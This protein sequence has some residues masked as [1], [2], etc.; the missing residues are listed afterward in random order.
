M[1]T[2]QIGF[3][4]QIPYTVI[5]TDKPTKCVAGTRK[6]SIMDLSTYSISALQTACQAETASYYS[7]E[8]HEPRYCV[9]LFRRAIVLRNQAAWNAIYTIYEGQVTR[10]VRAESGQHDPQ[11]VAQLTNDAFTRFWQAV[12]AEKFKSHL[13]QLGQLL[14]YLKMC[15]Q[16]AYYD[17]QRRAKKARHDIAIEQLTQPL[18]SREPLVEWVVSQQISA[19][20]LWQWVWE[21][22]KND[23]ERLVSEL[24]LCYELTPKQIFESY[25]ERFANVQRIY[26]IHE[27][28]LRRLRRRAQ[29]A[30]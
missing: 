28:V 13:N 1:I 6:R 25:P 30:E 17:D 19:D 14:Q 12:S 5:I 15:A 27:N 9:E 21:Q 29:M 20:D 8:P 26:R 7:G 22:L 16:S 10:W 4:Q 24:I 23:D 3:S 11:R 18:H 2:P